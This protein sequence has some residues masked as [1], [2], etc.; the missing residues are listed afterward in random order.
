[1]LRNCTVFLLPRRQTQSA[2]YGSQ[3]FDSDKWPTVLVRNVKGNR[4]VLRQICVDH[5]ILLS[6]HLSHH[7][8]FMTNGY[9]RFLETNSSDPR[10]RVPLKYQYDMEPIDS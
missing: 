7:V 2:I 8:H 6:K 10:Q 9:K 5:C 1:M 3:M 4:A